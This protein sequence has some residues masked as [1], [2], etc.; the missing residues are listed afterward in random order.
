M[1]NPDFIIN[2]K[3]ATLLDRENRN[4]DINPSKKANATQK[5]NVANEQVPS[6]LFDAYEQQVW[7][8]APVSL[9][10]TDK[11]TNPTNKLL[12]VTVDRSAKAK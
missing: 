8:N 5:K 6:A 4:K 11:N 12:I 10:I 9:P 2:K 7:P 3:N 1:V